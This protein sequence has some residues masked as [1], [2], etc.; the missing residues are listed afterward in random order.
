MIMDHSLPQANRFG[1][2][3]PGLY[4]LVECFDDPFSKLT[5]K[6]IIVEERVKDA[7]P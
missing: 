4:C 7:R 5:M 2:D 3:T 1:I 6:T